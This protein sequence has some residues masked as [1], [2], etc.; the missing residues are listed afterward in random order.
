[1][2][3]WPL[4]PPTD[5]ELSHIPLNLG[6]P[7]GDQFQGA[8]DIE[9]GGIAWGYMAWAGHVGYVKHQY[10]MHHETAEV[11]PLIHVTHVHKHGL[12]NF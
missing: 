3:L 11:P 7:T 12:I 5:I 4:P 8:I 10:L 9:V 1:M 6:G 2:G